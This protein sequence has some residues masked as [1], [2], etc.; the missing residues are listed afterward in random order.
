MSAAH[1]LVVATPVY[2]A[3][4]TGVLKVFLDGL[5]ATSLES[6]VVVPV[7]LAASRAHGALADL[8]LRI[9]L[10]ALGALLPVPSFVLE[11]H[12][13]DHLPEYVEAWRHRFGPV[14]AAVAT[15]L[16]GDEHA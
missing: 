2:K 12:H 14:V 6:T 1:V 9:V 5:S 8:Q 15:A 11:E 16:Q 10:Q 13:L 4:Y 3:S 7:V